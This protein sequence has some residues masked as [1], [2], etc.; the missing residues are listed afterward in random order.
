MLF[1]PWLFISL[2]KIFYQSESAEI[3]GLFSLPK[4]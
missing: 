4:K 3:E 2:E 1:S